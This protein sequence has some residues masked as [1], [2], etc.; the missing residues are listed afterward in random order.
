MARG[1]V[2]VATGDSF[3]KGAALS[4]ATLRRDYAGPVMVL[5]D[6]KAPQFAAFAKKY[7]VTVNIQATGE[8][9]AG[10]SSRLLK[11]RTA[12][13]CPYETTLFL[14]ADT[15]VLKPVRHI[16]DYLTCGHPM[17]MTLSQFHSKVKDVANS[18]QVLVNKSKR[19]IRDFKATQELTGPNFPYWS[20]STMLWHR[21]SQVLRLFDTWYAE[22]CRSRGAD[23][24]ALARALHKTG[25]SVAQMPR[26]F[27]QR[28]K[29]GPH[30]DTVIHTPGISPLAVHC[31]AR[32]PGLTETVYR[33]FT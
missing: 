33:L 9:H 30:P 23:M 27:N 13:L 12:L 32:F 8:A 5:T 4:I 14:D 11:T 16:W 17:A 31:S 29:Q 22:W 6:K 10:I 18:K 19:C 28:R 7:R 21:T 2:Y 20:S 25:V 24:L 1:V 26:Q 3:L 15:L